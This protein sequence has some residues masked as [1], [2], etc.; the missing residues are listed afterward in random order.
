MKGYLLLDKAIGTTLPD[1]NGGMLAQAFTASP[2]VPDKANKS[3]FGAADPS[4]MFSA[5]LFKGQRL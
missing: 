4:R 5:S 1:L 2:F 3:L